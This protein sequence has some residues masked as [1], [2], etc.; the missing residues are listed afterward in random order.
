MVNVDTTY[1]PWLISFVLLA[2]TAG[3]VGAG[4]LLDFVVNARRVR[5]TPDRPVADHDRGMAVSR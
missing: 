4:A 1:M 3:I 5:V 2:V